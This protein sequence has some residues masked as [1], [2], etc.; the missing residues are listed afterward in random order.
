[1]DNK[2]RCKWCNLKNP[3]YIDYHDN[4]WC[5]INGKMVEFSGSS[6]FEKQI[7]KADISKLVKVGENFA[8]I[9]TKLKGK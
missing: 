9:K 3:K 2:K 5:K 6:E 7:Y 1:M 8:E 4:E